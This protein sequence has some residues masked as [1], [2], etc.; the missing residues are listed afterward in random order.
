V[1]DSTP[2]APIV[3]SNSV[4]CQ[5]DTLKLFA[6]DSTDSVSYAWFGP[7]GFSSIQQ[8][9]Y[10]TNVDTA[11]GGVY[12]VSALLGMCATSTATTVSV[13]AT[14]SFIPTSNSP[15]CSGDTLKL[16]AN[17]IPGSGYSWAGPY[18]FYAQSVASDP[19]VG[20]VTTENAGIYTV[21]ATLNGCPTSEEDTVVVN[22]TPAPPFVSWLTYCQY[23]AAPPL[24]AT[25]ENITWY[26]TDVL[27]GGS[28]TPPVP[29]TSVVG[30]TFYYTA[31][32]VSNCSSALDSIQVT[33]NPTPHVTVSPVDTGVCPHSSF[34][35]TAVDTDAVANYQWIPTIYLGSST[36]DT[37][38]VNPET[39]ETY[40]VIASNQYGCSDT[41]TVHITVYP[42]ALISLPDSVTLY[43]GETYTISP[44]TNC[45]SFS[46]Y[47]SSGLSGTTVPDPVANP[48]V[49]TKY[50][51]SGQTDNGCSTTD[52][53]SINVSANSLLAL[54][55]AF[56][57]GNGPNNEF[58][59]IKKGE[60]TLNYFRIFDRW[61]QKVFE[62]TDV[63]AGWDGTFKGT[64]QPL[65][66]YVYEIEAV[67]SNGQNFV[68]Q[69]NVTLLR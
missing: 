28:S 68:M 58:K 6:A 7:G 50:I 49:S 48:A 31:Q 18:A 14:P 51:V 4:V 22:T 37:V 32:T 36:T 66:V 56:T 42:A 54:P 55:N 41:D 10:I 26:A 16:H 61:G 38:T 27:T 20:N 46:W 23:Y 60:A 43:P 33:V 39:D 1:V 17:G 63:N 69:G 21:T 11:A 19:L 30:A 44:T 59:V 67:T 53:I 24:M 45:T 8:D 57:P 47:P 64:P 35:L 65:G 40:E 9:P 25:G 29:N 13:T 15:V 5:G 3:F 52:S 62:T 12:S 2:L 34:L